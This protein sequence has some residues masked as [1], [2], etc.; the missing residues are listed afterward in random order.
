[1]T[2]SNIYKYH[3]VKSVLDR[4]SKKT[5]YK[6]EVIGSIR[7]KG[8]S[9]HDI[10]ILLKNKIPFGYEE[11]KII[12]INDISKL[13]YLLKSEFQKRYKSPIKLDLWINAGSGKTYLVRRKGKTVDLEEHN[14]GGFLRI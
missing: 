8:V 2:K 5:G 11:E 6:L 13:L 10:D 3:D 4:L 1:M 12:S 14:I 7:S 9:S